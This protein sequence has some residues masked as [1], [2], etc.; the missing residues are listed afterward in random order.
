MARGIFTSLTSDQ[1]D[2]RPIWTPDGKRI[3]FTSS[4]MGP[5][6]LFWMPA[7]GSG[8]PERLFTSQYTQFPSSW[9]PDGR[10]LGFMEI[11]P[12]TGWDLWVLPRDDRSKPQPF[13]QTR[14]D[15]GW[16]EFSPDSRWV[17][18]TAND[19]GRWEV[20]V[21]P[22]PGPGGKVQISSEGGTE[23]VWGRTGQELFYRNRDKMM[24][25]AVTM[26]P[27][28]SAAK[29]RLLFEGRYEMGPVPGMVNYDVARDGQR[30][31]M[32]KSQ[33]ASSPAQLDVVLDW[34]SEVTR[35][36]PSR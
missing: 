33:H 13:L 15:E 1:A 26:E 10:Y 25:V 32:L 6:N 22:F 11:H 23:A 34:F 27:T 21:R 3:T 29:P 30:F 7:D 28:F 18:Y 8:P 36:A 5:L 2:V 31:L 9:S 19:S 4:R 16:L 24:T 12:A 35:R 20:Y 17:A 14:F